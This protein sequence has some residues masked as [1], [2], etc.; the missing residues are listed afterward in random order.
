MVQTTLPMFHEA[1]TPYTTTRVFVVHPYLL[2]DAIIAKPFQ[3]TLAEKSIAQNTAVILPTGLGK[4][5]IAF[6]VIAHYLPKKILFL[7]PTKPLVLQHYE[8]CKKFLNIPSEKIVLVSGSVP[9]KKRIKLIADALVVVATPQTIAHDILKNRYAVNDFSLIIFDEMHKAV[10]KYAYVTIAQ[11]F[12]GRV[13]G[14]TAS[15]GSQKKKIAQILGNLNIAHIESRVHKDIDVMPHVKDISVEWI[16]ISQNPAIKKIQEPLELLFLETLKKL[17]RLGILAYKKPN[18]ISKKDILASRA[19]IQKRFGRRPYAFAAY[20]NQ[21][22]LLQIYHCLEL[23]ETQGVDSFIKYLEKFSEKEKLTSSEKW[24]ITHESVQKTI[25]LANNSQ[26]NSV[27]SHPKLPVLKEIIEKQFAA[28]P[29]SLILI[30]TQY[31]A[32]IDSILKILQE[33]P[34]ARPTYFVGQSKLGT[35]GSVAGMSQH[36]QKEILEKFKTRELNVLV[37]T[38]VAEEGID[39]P[40]VSRVIFYEPIPSEIRTIQR[41]GRTGRSSVGQVTILITE[42]TRDEAYLYAEVRKEKKMQGIIKGMKIKSRN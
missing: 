38:S 33:I 19:V 41:K 27:V 15:P 7:A 8:S 40:N 3:I 5:I 11:N 21:A 4:T 22:I 13:L 1:R 32:T 31:R 42:D 17:N 34:Q 9:A 24:F 37:A 10:E 26:K 30:F 2:Q 29:D 16:K 25:V 6:L 36:Q 18:Y 12:C 14:L 20:R 23:L 35:H 28:N 39:I